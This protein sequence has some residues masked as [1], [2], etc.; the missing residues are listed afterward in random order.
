M[1]QLAKKQDA[2]H[3]ENA[4]RLPVKK[5]AAKKKATV[6]LLRQ[7]RKHV[8]KNNKYFNHQKKL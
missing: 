4:M 5:N 1:K 7:K 6:L 2:K 8:A 3:Q